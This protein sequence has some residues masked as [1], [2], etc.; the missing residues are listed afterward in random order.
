MPD[1]FIVT[2]IKSVVLV[3]LVM[4]VFAILTWVERRLLGRFQVR[5]GPN[6]VGPFGLLQPIADLG[7][8]LRKESLIPVG[9]NPLLYLTA[10]VVSLF[11]SLAVFG[12]IPFGERGHDP[13]HRLQDLPLHL[14][15]ER[16][17]A[18]GLRA[19]LVQLLR[20]PGRRLVVQLE[21]LAVRLDARRRP[22]GLLRGQR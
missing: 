14:E 2:L 13:V 1:G 20:V 8:L 15:S 21:V 4:G 3:N 11:A 9:V 17:A 16:G 12:V 18:A 19:G 7:K 5:L 6:R 22:A 10:P